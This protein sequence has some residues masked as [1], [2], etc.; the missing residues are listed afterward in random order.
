MGC[1]CTGHS[2][3]HSCSAVGWWGPRICGSFKRLPTQL[4]LGLVQ[5]VLVVSQPPLRL[6]ACVLTRMP[7]AVAC[8]AAG[9]EVALDGGEAAGRLADDDLM[10]L[11]GALANNTSLRV[12]P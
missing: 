8:T 4:A 2:L 11:A 10:C 12:R 5:G 1:L 7:R 3:G 6:Q 9:S